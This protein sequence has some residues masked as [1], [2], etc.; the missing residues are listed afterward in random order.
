MII[1]RWNGTSFSEEFPKTKASMLYASDGETTIFD[2][3]T[4]IK[5]S[6][7]PNEVFDS[8]HYFNAV[9]A[10]GDF[11]DLLALVRLDSVTQGRSPNGYYYVAT[12]GINMGYNGLTPAISS[13]DAG[14]YY[15]VS[16]GSQDNMGD[17]TVVLEAG[18]WFIFSEF[19]GAGTEGNPYKARVSCVNNTYEIASST[20]YGIMKLIS[21]TAQSVAAQAVTSTTARTYGIQ[22]NGSG[23]MVV[24]VPWV[25]TNTTYSMM[26]DTVLGLGKLFNN[27]AQTVAANTATT[28][29]SRTYGIQKNSS[30]QLVVNVPWVDT[31]TTYDKAT[32]SV[33][34]LIELFNDTVQTVAA[35]A[36]TTTASRTY[37]LQLDSNDRAVVNVPWTDNNT[38]YSQATTSALGLVQLGVAA[39]NATVQTATTTAGRFYHV[40]AQADGKLY[41]NVPWV[42]TDTNTT[43]TAGTNGGLT[44]DSTAFRMTYPLFV[45][46]SQPTT[47]VTGAIWFDTN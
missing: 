14:K 15:A 3:N 37:G 8:L 38:T 31:N 7:L 21:D 36:V 45:Q 17:E 34:G 40:G 12:T 18:D 19:G 29:A 22:N 4:K 47:T 35:N 11:Y 25:D 32:S 42:D 28:T 27:T 9:G 10:N 1:K 41:V 16:I 43:Y 24:N 46:S 6:Y 13:N 44:L 5:T 2:A 30:D 20:N 33:L 26:S 23:Q 39:T